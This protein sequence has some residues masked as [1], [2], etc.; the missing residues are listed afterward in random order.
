MA[1]KV[2]HN[3]VDW[4][5]AENIED[6]PKV[7]KE[8]TGYEPDEYEVEDYEELDSEDSF[9][10]W[11][12]DSVWADPPPKDTY[13]SGGKLWFNDQEDEGNIC[14]MV[15]ATHQQW[16]EHIGRGFLGSTEF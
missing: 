2:F 14:W 16:I 7:L 13:P 11:F 3:D 15:T 10:M 9:T 4:V 6:V 12:V 8:H 1:L 5:I